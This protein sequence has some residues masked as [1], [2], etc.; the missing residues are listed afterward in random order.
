MRL[1]AIAC[2]VLARPVYLGA[3]RSPHVVDVTLLRRGL[4]AEPP[5]LRDRLQAEIDRAAAGH[6]GTSAP[7]A[8]VLAFGL[9][10]GATAGLEA[11]TVPVVLPRAHDCITL[12]LGSRERYA[13]E[14]AA[15]PTYW[16]VQDQLERGDAGGVAVGGSGAAGAGAGLA[17]DT[18]AQM[19]ELRASYVATYGEDNAEYLM[20]V[21]GAW[22]THYRRGAYVALESDGDGRRGDAEAVA[23]AEAERRGWLFERVEGDLVL[24][25]RLLNGDWGDDVL[26]LR[27]GERLAMSYDAGVVK[28]VSAAG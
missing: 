27:P 14:S 9:C 28:A 24:V 8:V 19:A 6:D 25:R 20:E 18:D 5:R 3:A 15:T 21:M 4:H 17:A 26:V 11:R 22:R 13:T 2:D 12:F 10:G 23:R 1:H 16:Y 7:D